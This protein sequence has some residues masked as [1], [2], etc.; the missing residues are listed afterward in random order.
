MKAVDMGNLSKGLLLGA[1]GMPGNTANFGLTEICKAKKGET[2]VVS[3]TAGT[4]GWGTLS[5]RSPKI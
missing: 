5:D 4:V 2:V 3:G 1:C